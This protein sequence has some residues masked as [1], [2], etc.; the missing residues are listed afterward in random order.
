VQLGSGNLPLVALGESLVHRSTVQHPAGSPD[1]GNTGRNTLTPDA[2][3][4]C[5]S[6]IIPASE[7]EFVD[8]LGRDAQR[9]PQF[10]VGALQI[11]HR[12]TLEKS[13]ALKAGGFRAEEPLPQ[14]S[15]PARHLNSNCA[16]TFLQEGAP[17]GLLRVADHP[18]GTRSAPFSA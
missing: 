14:S 18:P 1:G 16:G 15:N 10:G 11:S 9:G 6:R 13:F 8:P 5:E 2:T 3:E 4:K 17:A 12:M 7:I